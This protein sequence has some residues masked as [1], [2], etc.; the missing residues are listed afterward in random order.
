METYIRPAQLGKYVSIGIPQRCKMSDSEE[1]TGVILDCADKSF[2]WVNLNPDNN[3][4]RFQYTSDRLAE[5][6][7]DETGT[8][9]VYK[10]ENLTINGNVNNI[11]VPAWEEIDGLIGNVIGSNNLQGVHSEILKCVRMLS[12]RR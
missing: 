6:W 8:W 4:M 12:L 3:L 9:N 1:S 5:G 7:N 2:K 10:P 11:N